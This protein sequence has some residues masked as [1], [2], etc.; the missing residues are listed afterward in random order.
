MRFVD[1]NLAKILIVLG[2]L[3]LLAALIQVVTSLPPRKF[4][5]L[6]GSEG[7]G[8]YIA[9]QSYQQIA[10]E[11]GFDLEIRTTTGPS[12]T[13]RLL[14]AGAADAGFVQ[15]GIASSGNP[16]VLSSLANVFYEPLWIFYRKDAAEA[17]LRRLYELIGKRIAV[18]AEGSGTQYLTTRLLAEAT[19]TPDNSTF[20]N[21]SFADAAKQL[22][23]G[24]V[25]AA[26]FVVSDAYPL[27][28]ELLKNPA[29][30]LMNMERADA[31]GF[32][33]PW[34]TT[35]VLPASGAD[36][37]LE[38]PSES[39]TMLATTAN[40]VVRNDLHPDLL[41]LLA[42]ATVLTH[43]R[44]GLFE[45]RYEFPNM[46]MTDLP[47]SATAQAY[48]GQLKRG[49]S[50]LDNHL[51]FWMAAVID[52]YLLFVLPVLLIVLP[53]VTRSPLVYQ[54]Y[55]RQK[56]VKWYRIVRDTELH[57]E[58]LQLGEI[59]DEIHKLADLDRKL[60][61]ELSVSNAYLPSVYELRTHVQFVS[62]RLQ[63]RKQQLIE[64]KAGGE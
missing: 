35:V 40:L 60:G 61:V 22:A 27:P 5:I 7:G 9:A 51:P 20:V 39:K 64:N 21:L 31:Y 44:G 4:T 34:L 15:G 23:A 26:L 59:D 28:W 38:I 18:G 8:Y 50:Y 45:N 12:E 25:D 32:R 43:Q 11:K 48:L 63:K 13:L 24:E 58:T 33:N 57:M 2:V 10:A 14:E 42:F 16:L 19:V 52:R 41:R 3:L 49:D 47:V 29:I 54:W 55:M 37:L 62:D 1:R 53:I 56:V 36:S 17:P 30:E 46:T 6:T